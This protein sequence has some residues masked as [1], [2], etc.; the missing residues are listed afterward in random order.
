[1]PGYRGS[2]PG[3]SMPGYSMPGYSMPSLRSTLGMAPIDSTPGY[4]TLG[5]CFCLS[6]IPPG[7]GEYAP[8]QAHDSDF[9]FRHIMQ[10]WNAGTLSWHTFDMHM[11]CLHALVCSMSDPQLG[12]ARLD[13]NVTPSQ[14][15]LSGASASSLRLCTSLLQGLPHSL[16]LSELRH[17]D[18]HVK[19]NCEGLAPSDAPV[20][21]RRVQ[22]GQ[23]TRI[24]PRRLSLSLR[25][26]DVWHVGHEQMPISLFVAHKAY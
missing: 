17:G 14:M 19:Q 22:M 23:D 5:I 1:M 15:V 12:H 4:S 18:V 2:M 7:Q 20:T 6:A 25:K 8:P 24:T 13:G 21:R 3:Y 10:N 9:G 11:M 16:K 26:H